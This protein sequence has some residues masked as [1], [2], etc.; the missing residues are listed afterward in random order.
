[1]MKFW[2]KVKEIETGKE[3][4]LCIISNQGYLSAEKQLLG[5]QGII[6]IEYLGW[7]EPLEDT[8][9]KEKLP[10]EREDK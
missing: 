10:G 9:P 3:R 5:I 1:M 8:N 2:F 4:E 6:P 7:T